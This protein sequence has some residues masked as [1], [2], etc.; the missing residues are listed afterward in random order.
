M[1]LLTRLKSFFWDEPKL[2]SIFTLPAVAG[3][4]LTGELWQQPLVDLCLRWYA[5]NFPE[6][7]LIAQRWSR[8]AGWLEQETGWAADCVRLINRPNAYYTRC[9]L[10]SATLLSWFCDGNAYWYI[11]R[12]QRGRAVEL[13]YLPHPSVTV[14]AGKTTDRFVERYEYRQAGQVVSLPV[15]DVVHFR[16]GIDPDCQQRGLSPL[17]NLMRELLTD[18]EASTYTTAVLQNLG[19][20]GALISPADPSAV[21]PPEQ[22]ELIKTTY[23]SRMT[24]RERGSAIVFP[25]GVRVDYPDVSPERMLLA[26]LREI[27]ETRVAAAFNLPPGVVG[28]LT[29]LQYTATY[30]NIAEARDAAYE[31]GV[32]PLQRR[33]AETLAQQFRLSENERI[34]FDNSNVRALQDD[35]EKRARMLNIGVAG[36]WIKL[37]E[38]RAAMG[39]PTDATEDVY[40]RNT[41]VVEYPIQ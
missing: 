21:I 22:A 40:L 13:W 36:G 32:L 25:T 4:Q 27:P 37:S 12:D 16:F 20:P 6:S 29:G 24:G 14:V 26:R 35:E 33:F 7:E 18:Q 3:G 17:A 10:W 38:A 2:G 11:A 8:R 1:G 15:E 9:D 39:L 23:Q 34:A 5:N 19:I 31:S 28:L 41:N 30:N